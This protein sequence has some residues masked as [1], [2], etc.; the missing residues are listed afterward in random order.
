MEK[1][2]YLFLGK[3]SFLNLGNV[4]FQENLASR[5]SPGHGESSP[6]R[7]AGLKGG[8]AANQALIFNLTKVNRK[9]LIKKNTPLRKKKTNRRRL[10]RKKSPRLGRTFTT[11]S[12]DN[13][14]MWR[15]KTIFLKEPLL[16]FRK[17][18]HL[19]RHQLQS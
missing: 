8:K 12:Q 18:G 7:G 5:K 10:H 3:K 15:D 9:N 6:S 4:V 1:G 13:S 11:N 14:S 17:I 19:G 16:P 2:A